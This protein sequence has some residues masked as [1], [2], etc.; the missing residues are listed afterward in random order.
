MNIEIMRLEIPRFQT[1]H[2]AGR[3]VN[4]FDIDGGKSG[5]VLARAKARSDLRSRCL[6]N[7]EA[8]LAAVRGPRHT[9]ILGE[10][11]R[12]RRHFDP[13]ADDSTSKLT[14]PLRTRNLCQASIDVGTHRYPISA[15]GFLYTLNRSPRAGS[16]RSGP[17]L[18]GR[19][20]LDESPA[21]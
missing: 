2:Q 7:A 4:M 14:H 3:T 19:Y 21:S 11:F 15:H 16:R 6:L 18:Y 10:R 1:V 13:A 20:Q 8:D 12:C 17:S 5:A 9:I